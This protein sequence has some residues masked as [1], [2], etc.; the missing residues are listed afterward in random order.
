MTEQTLVLIK[1]DAIERGLAGEIISRL[2]KL[3]LKI[4]EIKMVRPDKDLAEKHYPVTE[5]WYQT[6][7]ERSLNDFKKYRVDTKEA[8]GTD[9][10]VEI[11]KMIHDW[12]VERFTGADIIAM[13]WEGV[14]AI[15]AVRKACGATIPLLAPAG[16]IRG[17]FATHSAVSENSVKTA[18]RNLVHAS[19]NP[20]EA[21][22]EINLWF[23]Q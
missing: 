20:E 21:K 12:N 23:G 2:E 18:I 7:G 14:N 17:D 10:A 16:T 9:D 4:A 8:L 3:G 11:G 15:E 19:G 13:V 1:P 22:R 5:E 6:V